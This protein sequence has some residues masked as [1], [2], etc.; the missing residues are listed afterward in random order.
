M[1]NFLLGSLDKFAIVQFL[2]VPV[3]MFPDSQLYKNK[4]L[5]IQEEDIL[6]FCLCKIIFKNTHFFPEVVN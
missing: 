3:D 4:V 5:I 2:Y 6:S 1:E